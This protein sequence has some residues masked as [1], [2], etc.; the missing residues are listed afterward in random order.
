VIALSQPDITDL[1]VEYATDA[2]RSTL[3][4]KGPYVDRFERTWAARC[5]TAHAVG[6]SSGTSALE[7]AMRGLG[8]GAADEVVVPAFTFAGVAA[9]VASTGAQP[10]LADVDPFTWCLDPDATAAAVTARTVGIVAVHSYGMPAAMGRLSEV[11]RSHGLWLVEDCAEAHGASI[12]G[13]AVG[14]LAD[15][16]TFSFFGNKIVAAG[17]GGAV[18]TADPVLA[19]N[20]RCLAN[21]GVPSAAPDRYHPTTVAGNHRM[22]NLAA[23]LLC[24]QAERMDD[25]LSRRRVV[26]CCY[27][28]ALP[29]DAMCWPVAPPGAVAVPWLVTGLVR[30]R[31]RDE[32]LHALAAAG[33]QARAVFPPVADLVPYRS[34]ADIP[35]ARRIA[36][37]GISLPT[38]P[39]LRVD[40]IEQIAAVITEALGTY[41][42]ASP[43]TSGSNRRSGTNHISATTT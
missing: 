19:E 31:A 12:D 41:P 14:G 1:E 2:L 13:R 38:H 26:E 7:L 42:A 24:A 8:C 17:E 23:A 39:C 6:V 16:G 37:S 22:T 25:L 9:A 35:T 33:V 10:V 27:R 30:H 20:V 3:L 43:R 18:T 4:S 21:Q 29:D 5:M 40:E 36:R 28:A 11:A 15:A 32:V 34:V